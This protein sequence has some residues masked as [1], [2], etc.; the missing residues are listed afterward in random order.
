VGK[1]GRG[2]RRWTFTL[3]GKRKS[4]QRKR[5][6]NGKLRHTPQRSGAGAKRKVGGK[7]VSSERRKHSES[8]KQRN[9]LQSNCADVKAKVGGGKQRATQTL[10]RTPMRSGSGRKEDASEE[11]ADAMENKSSIERLLDEAHSH[12]SEGRYEE[13][14]TILNP[15]VELIPDK[16]I[17]WGMRGQTY[18]KL[19]RYEEALADWNRVLEL[20]PD[21]KVALRVRGNI[22]ESARRATSSLRQTGLDAEGSSVNGTIVDTPAPAGT[23]S[24]AWPGRTKEQPV[25]PPRPRDTGGRRRPLWVLAGFGFLAVMVLAGLGVRL[26]VAGSTF[27]PD[28]IGGGAETVEVPSLQGQELAAARQKVGDDFELVSSEVTSNQPKGAI[29][30]QD[31]RAGAEVQKGGEISVVVSSGIEMVA[32]PDVV[33]EPRNEA[34]EVLRSEGFEVKA[35][36]RESSKEEQGEVM[37]QSPSAGSEAEKNSTVAITVG[38]GPPEQASR[39]AEDAGPAPGYN[40]IQ[41]LDGGLSVE[42]PPSW[43]VETGEDSEKEAGPNTWSYYAGEY[44]TSSITTASSLDAWYSSGDVSGA[45]IVASRALAQRYTDDELIH[46][47]LF[48]GKADQCTPGPYKDFDRPPYSGKIQTWYDCG[49]NDVTSF[50]VAAA[51]EGRECVVVLDARLANDADREAIQHILDSFEVNC[52]TIAKAKTEDRN[53]EFANADE[54][55]PSRQEGSDLARRQA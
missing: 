13:A 5:N 30:S 47:L 32:V 1:V 31:P 37:L 24:Q 22:Q 43:G 3:R 25:S 49:V 19:G 14:L 26:G 27:L 2:A 44:L 42:V 7:L 50:T 4:N 15:L 51:P 12:Y 45:Y 55:I 39:P 52:G 21:N 18:H 36:T 16:P 17:G 10:L 40:L 20:D 6:E 29:L 28:L 48:K 53:T 41:T 34:E 35:E 46:F 8:G 9:E 38:E 54:S 11:V 23:G 33:G